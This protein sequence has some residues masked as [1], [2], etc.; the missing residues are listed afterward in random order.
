MKK[1]IVTI[2][3]IG[4]LLVGINQTNWIVVSFCE[5]QVYRDDIDRWAVI[6]GISD[7]QGS[8]H[9][10]DIPAKEAQTLYDTLQNKDNRWNSSNMQLLL[11]DRATKQN[12]L[13]ALNWLRINADFDDIVLFSFNGHGGFI[14]DT[15]GDEIID[16]R[17]ETIIT[18]ELSD[19]TDDELEYNFGEISEKNINGMFL[20]FDCCLSGGLFNW[21]KKSIDEL[22][23][24]KE[25]SNSL[26]SEICEANNFTKEITLDMNINNKVIVASSIPRGLAVCFNGAEGWFDFTT[27]INTAIDKGM[28]TA[29]DIS[30]YARLWWLTRPEFFMMFLNPFYWMFNLIYLMELGVIIMPLPILKDGYPFSDPQLGKLGIL[31]ISDGCDE[32]DNQNCGQKLSIT[33]IS[34]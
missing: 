32:I 9:D 30:K 13:D 15:N 17:D 21:G 31:N 2:L 20:I 27:G 4:F 25:M 28:K 26:K 18:W 29:E 14:E 24:D 11:D 7:Y 23:L 10:L 8:D 12:I 16:G 19:I 33:A 6:I 5:K 1:T 34:Q 3:I 22:Y